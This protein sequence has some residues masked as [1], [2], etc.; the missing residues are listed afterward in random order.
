LLSIE[1]FSHDTNGTFC[2]SGRIKSGHVCVGD[3]MNIAG[4]GHQD[5]Y[6]VSSIKMGFRN[7]SLKNVEAAE[8]GDF[9]QVLFEEPAKREY[10]SNHVLVK[11]SCEM[12]RSFEALL[13]LPNH[14]AG[15]QYEPI[16]LQN[17]EAL[18]FYC[19]KIE[20]C[21]L[22]PQAAEFIG[23]TIMHVSIKLPK[24]YV[25][26][27]FQPFKVCGNSRRAYGIILP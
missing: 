10:S 9:I 6:T 11:S 26:N 8:A 17:V 14:Y 12:K 13:Y 2:L 3:V 1:D 18:Q 4:A 27:A 7:I 15:R 23:S 22:T 25:L 21:Y 16:Q 20:N 24:S 19:G 5:R